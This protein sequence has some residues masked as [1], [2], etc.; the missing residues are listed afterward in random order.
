MKTI[1]KNIQKC[2]YF[3]KTTQPPL[4]VPPSTDEA[5]TDNAVVD[6]E[7]TEVEQAPKEIEGPD[8]VKATETAAPVKEAAETSS[9]S[10]KHE[11]QEAPS[12]NA[13]PV[14]SFPPQHPL[15]PVAGSIT[16]GPQ[17]AQPNLQTLPQLVPQQNIL[18]PTGQPGTI[19]LQPVPPGHPLHVQPT[20][21]RAV[22]Q[23]YFKQHQ[24][25]QQ[26]RPLAEVLGAG[27]FYFLQ[28]SELDS[29]E[30]IANANAVPPTAP[31]QQP[32]P[33]PPQLQQTSQPPLQQQ[34]TMHQ[35]SPQSQIVTQT[36]TNQAFPNVV[37]GNMKPPTSGDVSGTQP[38]QMQQQQP[39]IPGFATANTP[40]PIPMVQ[41][42]PIPVATTIPQQS[43][44][45]SNA[46]LH[47]P[48]PQSIGAFPPAGKFI[49]PSRNSAPQSKI[50]ADNSKDHRS[51]ATLS[52]NKSETIP[53]ITDW[54]P[55]DSGRTSLPSK[56]KH[57]VHHSKEIDDNSNE[58]RDPYNVPGTN[59]ESG[60]WNPV[61]NGTSQEE[62]NTWPS[63]NSS[64]PRYQ[65]RQGPG[66]YRNG[67]RPSGPGRNNSV[68][69][70]VGSTNS[71]T[72]GYRGRQN[73]SY[74]SN[75]GR[76]NGG[77][78]GSNSGTFYRNNDPTYYQNG[79][80]GG[81]GEK[82]DSYNRTG[83]YRPRDT[84]TTSGS[85]FKSGQPMPQRNP[86]QTISSTANRDN[87]NRGGGHNNNN[88][89]NNNNQNQSHR[90]ANTNNNNNPTTRGINAPNKHH[91][92]GNSASS[93]SYGRPPAAGGVRS[94][95]QQTIN[96]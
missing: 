20:T 62:S 22:E 11:F 79:S 57:S 87:D 86:N 50:A 37:Y 78:S 1:I 48:P 58:W 69:P 68:G 49:P 23:A 82:S 4:P 32:Q 56:P 96:A 36:F 70:G 80:R 2:A 89:I 10:N 41:Q 7:K 5:A 52:K 93:S 25:I 55:E 43:N 53:E 66:G 92:G 47:T 21:V 45:K 8:A 26:M 14:P 9:D 19:Q 73:S 54:K 84:N 61:T 16:T 59:T 3:D 34:P 63:G 77:N 15:N 75:T 27:N 67:P 28:E 90:S 51:N 13:V 83:N 64:N 76:S 35:T 46:A 33:L 71:T 38:Q 39:H 44:S 88:S 85:S 17:K 12:A 42:A 74:Q 91:A 30:V 18:A 94:Q 81:G 60:E 6:E 31:Q 72:N 65:Y 24:Y 29:P 40:I 95:P